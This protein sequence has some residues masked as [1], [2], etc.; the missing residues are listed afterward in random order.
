MICTLCGLISL[1]PLAVH[2]AH[3]IC[4][5]PS[6]RMSHVLRMRLITW[7]ELCVLDDPVVTFIPPALQSKTVQK[8]R[9]REL[10]L[11]GKEQAKK[12]GG[13]SR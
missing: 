5:P 3:P 1:R 12:V 4:V 7:M 6:S 11:A 9:G 10:L 13:I 2:C 8:Q